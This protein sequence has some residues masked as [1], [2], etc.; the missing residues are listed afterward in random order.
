MW[1]VRERQADALPPIPRQSRAAVQ[2]Q[3]RA[4]VEL[5]GDI[6]LCREDGGEGQSGGQDRSGGAA[7]H[8]LRR[9]LRRADRGGIGR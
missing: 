2:P 3:W 1:S 9:G 4:G 7:R 8:C 6:D 5:C